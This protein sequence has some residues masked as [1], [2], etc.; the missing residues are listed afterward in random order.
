MRRQVRLFAT[1]CGLMAVGAVCAHAQ[2]G[3]VENIFNQYASQQSLW[4]SVASKYA[5]NLFGYLA[6]LDFAWTACILALEG[7]EL[8]TWTAR[9]IRKL[10]TIGFF[11]ILLINGQKWMQWIIDSFTQIGQDAAGGNGTVIL[12]QLNKAALSLASNM[13]IWCSQSATAMGMFALAPIVPIL[14]CLVILVSVYVGFLIVAI[15]FMVTQI[16]AFIVIGAGY[17]FLGFGGSQ[18]TRPYT[19]RYLS[20]A[21]SVGTRL[22]ILYMVMGLGVNLANNWTTQIGNLQTMNGCTV[23]SVGAPGSAP[24]TGDGTASGDSTTT[25]L[26][27]FWAVFAG[28]LSVRSSLHVCAALCCVSA[29]RCAVVIG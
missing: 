6:I 25:A 7:H 2:T 14:V 9:I 21:I 11:A 12:D 5:K 20:L 23:S 10:M 4:I 1:I 17:I 26:T 24:C 19:E 15:N 22:M 13:L 3:A 27:T 8:T 28:A 18:W 16:E 29:K